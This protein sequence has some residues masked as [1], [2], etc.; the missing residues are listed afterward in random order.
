MPETKML[1]KRKMNEQDPNR[2]K[3]EITGSEQGVAGERVGLT[4]E[5]REGNQEN[6]GSTCSGKDPYVPRNPVKKESKK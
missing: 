2:M 6:E 4:E 5:R 1:D 3:D